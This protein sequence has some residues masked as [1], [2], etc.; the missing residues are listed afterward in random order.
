[1]NKKD[2]TQRDIC[3]KCITPAVTN[4]GWDCRPPLK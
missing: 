3:S 4:A 2:L 1:M